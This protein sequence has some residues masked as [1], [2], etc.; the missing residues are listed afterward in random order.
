M[1]VSN[2]EH[3]LKVLVWISSTPLGIVT[4][5]NEAQF[6]KLIFVI[7]LG[8]V[9]DFRNLQSLKLTSVIPLGI[10]IEVIPEALNAEP[11]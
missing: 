5:I 9:T 2:S 7:V 1:M 8:S 11:I 4:D 3:P 10:T 6:K